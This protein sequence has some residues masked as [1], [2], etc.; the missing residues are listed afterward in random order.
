MYREQQLDS[1]VQEEQLPLPDTIEAH[2]ELI[3]EREA[4]QKMKE[5]IWDQV[6][7]NHRVLKLNANKPGPSLE[8]L[9]TYA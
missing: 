3:R 8:R 5:E 9:S 7:A 4:K 1:L 2:L 6:S